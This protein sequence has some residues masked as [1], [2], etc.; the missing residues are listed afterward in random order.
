MKRQCVCLGTRIQQL[1]LP[2]QGV[3][4]CLGL[5]HV[6]DAVNVER[7]LLGVCAPVLVV[8]AIDVLAVLGS[9]ERVVA[10]GNAAFVDLE[11]AGG[12]L[13]LRTHG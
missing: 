3:L 13:D 5:G 4:R 6:D 1:T 8:E 7:N 9:V 11:A 2:L 10:R 12:S